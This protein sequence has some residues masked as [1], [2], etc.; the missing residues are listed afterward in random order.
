MGGL[1]DMQVEYLL[2]TEGVG[3]MAESIQSGLVQATQVAREAAVRRAANG[4]HFA[5]FGETGLDD[6]DLVRMVQAVPSA[7]AAALGRKTYYFVPLALAEGRN[8]ESAGHRSGNEETTISPVYT[9]ELAEQAICHRN[10]ALGAGA[11]KGTGKNDEGSEGV[12]ISTRL[13]SDRFSLAFELF[14]NV[15]HAFVDAA[16]VPE[17]F[18]ELAWNQAVTDVRGE[19]SL[20][21]WECRAQAVG[22]GQNAGREGGPKIDEKAR[23]EFIEAAFSDAIAIYLLSLSVDFD[24]SELRE[25][26]Y[27]LLAPQALAERLRLV[28]RLFPP[29]AEYEF[30]IRYRRRA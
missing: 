12:F 19:T 10:V 26:E 24:Y 5:T 28:A 21:A 17:S 13:L 9:A 6:A 8:T 20:D 2:M 14:I 4:V 3:T 25:R 11:E 27:P 18:S 16:G 7:V 15:G 23:T 22:G 30:A 1:R 29:N